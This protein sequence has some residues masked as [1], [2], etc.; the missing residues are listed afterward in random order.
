MNKT[1]SFEE[2]H[3]IQVLYL[4]YLFIIHFLSLVLVEEKTFATEKLTDESQQLEEKKMK[5]LWSARAAPVDY[6]DKASLPQSGQL[7]QHELRSAVINHLSKSAGIYQIIIV[8]KYI[9]I[10]QTCGKAARDSSLNYNLQW[11]LKTMDKR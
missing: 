9:H 6:S 5:P 7:S 2:K 3:D 10:T 11:H 4:F 8:L 1:S